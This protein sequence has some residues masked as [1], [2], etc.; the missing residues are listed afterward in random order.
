MQ[1][2]SGSDVRLDKV[3]PLQQAI[4]AGTYSVPSADVAGK[5]MDAL[6]G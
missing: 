4:L 1:A 6:I 2:M 3:I 5:L